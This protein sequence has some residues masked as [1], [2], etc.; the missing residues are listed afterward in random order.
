LTIFSEIGS[1]VVSAHVLARPQP[2]VP[3]CMVPPNAR[4]ATFV[5]WSLGFIKSDK[6][7]TVIFIGIFFVTT[8]N[9]KIKKLSVKKVVLKFPTV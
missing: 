9:I 4:V 1:A 3:C 7:E 2:P 8:K 6:L 5:N